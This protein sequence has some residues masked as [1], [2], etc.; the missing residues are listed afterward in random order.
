MHI[1]VSNCSGGEVTRQRQES[2]ANNEVRKPTHQG[3]SPTPHVPISYAHR[4]HNTKHNIF[5]HIH[6]GHQDPAY[7]RG[8]STF[9][10][11][12]FPT[13]FSL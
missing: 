7:R 1:R 9:K 2:R 6:S 8:T 11:S 10:P 5:A 3:S 4:Q 13:L 12:V